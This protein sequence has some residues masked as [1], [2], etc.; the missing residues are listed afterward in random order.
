MIECNP[1]MQRLSAF[2]LLILLL[3]ACAAAPSAPV[4]DPTPAA[5]V[6]VTVPPLPA[7]QS[8]TPAS[9]VA[10]P[11]PQPTATT[12]GPIGG[13]SGKLLSDPDLG[14]SF[15]Y[16]SEWQILARPADAPPGVT[17]HAPPVGQ[18]PEPII[19]AITVDVNPA[20]ESSVRDVVDQQLA[21]VPPDLAA[22]INRRS[23]T[24]GGE[25]AEQ[26]LGLPSLAGAIEAFVLH[27]GQLYLIILQPYDEENASLTP[28][29][30]PARSAYDQVLA[31]WKFLK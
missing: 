26:V 4:A 27:S 18:G 8:P 14:I 13:A 16:P 21:Q 9:A 3:A 7:A 11:S 6:Y 5:P 24:I 12:E 10:T 20:P 17:L 31:S 28:Y 29:L 23:L 19:F 15:N 1:D 22:S 2:L 30:P 25:R